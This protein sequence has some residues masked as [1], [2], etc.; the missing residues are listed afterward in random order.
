[1]RQ[2]WTWFDQART[3]IFKSRVKIL[4]CSIFDILVSVMPVVYVISDYKNGLKYIMY[5]IAFTMML[6][7]VHYINGSHKKSP[8]ISNWFVGENH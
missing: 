6:L 2:R 8:I 5:T 4:I 3:D 1:M 7:T